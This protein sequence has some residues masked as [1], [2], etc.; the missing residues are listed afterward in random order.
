MDNTSRKL[1]QELQ[2]HIGWPVLEE[3][4]AEYLKGLELEGTIKR[5]SEFETIWQRAE[6]EGGRDHLINFFKALE[7]EARKYN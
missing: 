5:N 3:F 2:T 7:D 1:L 6:A 4:L